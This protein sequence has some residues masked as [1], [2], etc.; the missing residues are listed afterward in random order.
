MFLQSLTRIK[1]VLI[2][3]L[4]CGCDLTLCA[5]P[6]E[7]IYVYIAWKSKMPLVHPLNFV[8]ERRK[9]LQVQI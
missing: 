7:R 9:Y 4:S 5:L 8:V 2:K 3:Q 1:S 6:L